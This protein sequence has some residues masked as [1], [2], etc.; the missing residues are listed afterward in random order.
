MKRVILDL[1]VGP[2]TTS[3]QSGLVRH[4]LLLCN[5][6]VSKFEVALI[7]GDIIHFIRIGHVEERFLGLV[8]V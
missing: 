3:Y 4:R 2:L 5:T 8:V 1:P 6:I 7:D